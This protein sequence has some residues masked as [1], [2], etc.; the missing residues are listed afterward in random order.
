MFFS[1]CK[2]NEIMDI[3]T[4]I[5][6]D[7]PFELERYLGTWYE[8]ARFDHSFE[9]GLQGTTATYTLRN[10]GKIEVLNQGFKGSL[11]GERK[12]AVGKAKIPDLNDPR[13]LKVSFFWFFYADY[14]ILEL[15]QDY[16]YALIGSKSD[17]YLWILSRKPQLDDHTRTFLL[18]RIILRGYNPEK[19]IWV[20][21]PDLNK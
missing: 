16:Q 20:D 11:N 4:T 2:Q 14:F 19:L 6:Y 13:R 3:N 1:G 17:R 18:Q 7:F 12:V 21:Q 15:G 8:I 5:D 9:R 10:D